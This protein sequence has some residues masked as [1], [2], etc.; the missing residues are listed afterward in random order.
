VKPLAVLDAQ[1]PKQHQRFL[2]VDVL[3]NGVPLQAPPDVDDRLDDQP[4]EVVAGQ[5][6]DETPVN[7]Q[8]VDREVSELT[9][10]PESRAEV[11]ERNRIRRCGDR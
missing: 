5:V 1:L 6:A 8:I 10:G 9:E 7:L 2:G 11:V 3:G 4:V